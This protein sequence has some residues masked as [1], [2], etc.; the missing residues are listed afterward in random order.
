MPENNASQNS[1]EETPQSNV[2]FVP[3]LLM[4][5]SLK[6]LPYESW[7]FFLTVVPNFISSSGTS[8]FAALKM[9]T[10]LRRNC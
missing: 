4:S 2:I 8:C 3:F 5:T 10:S 9:L 7:A 6:K 1:T